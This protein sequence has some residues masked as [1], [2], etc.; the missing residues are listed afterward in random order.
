MQPI[1][2]LW[3]PLGGVA[4]IWAQPPLPPPSPVVPG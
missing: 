1:P 4:E 3:W 2:G